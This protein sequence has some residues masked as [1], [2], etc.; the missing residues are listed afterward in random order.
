MDIHT[1]YRSSLFFQLYRKYRHLQR[2]WL[3]IRAANAAK[4]QWH[5]PATGM[6]IIGVTGTD[7]KTT[8]ATMLASILRASGRKVGL[9][10]TVQAV[11]ND[12]SIDTGHHVSTP[13]PA[14]VYTLL[15]QMKQ[16]RVDDV[17]IEATSHGLDQ[18][19]LHGINFDVGIVTNISPEHLDYHGTMSRYVDA[20]SR[21]IKLSRQVVLNA[22]NDLVIS[23]NNHY[24]R[25][26][27]TFGLIESAEV[28][29]QNITVLADRTSFTAKLTSDKSL[30]ITLA[31][32]GQ[33]NILNALAAIAAADLLDSP[34][35]AIQQGLEKVNVD[36]RWEVVQ[37]QPFTVIIDFAHTPQAF[38][39]ILPLARQL[40]SGQGKVIHVFGSAAQRDETKRSM[41][42]ELS[43]K[44]ADITIITMEDPRFESLDRIQGMLAAGLVASGKVEHEDWHRIDDRRQA[45]DKALSLARPGDVVIIT[46]KGHEQS[47]SI[48]G[49]EH[50]WSDIKITRELLRQ[51]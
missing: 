50:P 22:D 47:M 25:P 36:G 40:V 18:R 44:W 19:R 42:G 17:I 23:M 43:G 4:R 2:V 48:R 49:Q 41:M 9:I 37:Q 33:F 29:A 11:I 34:D 30:P 45:I 24:Q 39:Q 51:H 8:T 16:A 3:N 27:R 28:T 38:E 6:R 31:M 32:P 35:T 1:L 13:G 26:Q 46:G 10:S 20:K 15:A 5:D 21:L 7:G 14:Q 12:E